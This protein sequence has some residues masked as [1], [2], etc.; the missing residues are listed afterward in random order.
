[1]FQR[2]LLIAVLIF[3]LGAVTFGAEGP[4][5]IYVAVNGNDDW[6]GA[7]AE[8]KPDRTDGPLATL[9]AA[10]N[11]VRD[12][13]AKAAGPLGTAAT[14]V[15]RGGRY[16]LAAP[17]VLTPQDSG[18]ESQPLTICCFEGEHPVLSGGRRLSFSREPDRGGEVWVAGLPAGLPG[19]IV[20]EMWVNGHR[21]TRARFPVTGYLK[22]ESSPD[23]AKD[24][25]H[26]V[27]S[28]HFNDGDLKAWP[29][30]AD[31]E[32]VVMSHWVESR[33]PVK[34]IDEK[35]KTVS[36]NKQTTN[37]LDPGDVYFLEGS[38]DFLT[39]PGQWC[40]DPSAKTI[41]Y[42]PLPGE[43][44][45]SIEAIVPALQQVMRLEGDPQAERFVEHVAFRGIGFSHAQWDLPDHDAKGNPGPSGYHQAD[46]SV[47]GAVFGQGVVDCRFD[48][49]FVEHVGGYGV[50]LA[51]GCRHNQLSR[52][53][54]DDLGAGGIKIGETA[55]RAADSDQ[56]FG[57][58]VSDCRIT[59]GGCFYPSGV[60]A[61]FGQTY[62]NILSHNEI[63]NFY[64]T[65]ISIGWTW[66]YGKSLPRNNLVENNHVH[67]I[68]V[69]WLTD[70]TSL[71]DQQRED[72]PILSDM[73]GIY[74]LGAQPGTIIRGNRFH[75]IAGI[76]Y[77]GWGI[78]FDE[79][80]TGILAEKNLVYRT[81]HGGLHQHYGRE[82]IFRNNII[83]YS[84]DWQIQRTRAEDHQSFSF[85][86]NIVYWDTGQAVSGNFK[87]FNVIFTHND[88]WAFDKGD[89]KFAG[90]SWA[91]WQDKGMDSDS[92]VADPRFVDPQHDN[93]H[94]ADDSPALKV[95]FEP[96]NLEDVGPRKK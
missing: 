93:F 55:M 72:G 14:I 41:R 1:V 70:S 24:W 87:S 45:Q 29:S 81:T 31:A 79:G 95:G 58:E 15:M 76:K 13:R 37:G 56:T 84:R 38:K 25:R 43:D 2:A 35:E 91:Q 47:P 42:L 6:S 23:S 69:K 71:K 12:L 19:D 26:S 60:A 59:N 51:R 28:F 74:T 22:V 11:R 21:R 39:E 96:F 65:G 64:Y 90:L 88:Y 18:T 67:H 80:S 36:F 10:R 17:F 5:T 92:I 94:I 40:E 4:M 48:G 16:E 83:A 54:I 3:S 68:G 53:I 9:E 34:D 63:A 61:W 77:G 46:I 57:N 7:L 44:P 82:N 62:D 30:A 89:M 75:D 50:E 86:H 85:E 49:C 8:A 20:R 52:C 33:L 32:L 27:S 78:Y 73:G 66:G